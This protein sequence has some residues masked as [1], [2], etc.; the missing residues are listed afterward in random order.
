MTS[1]TAAAAVTGGFTATDPADERPLL[2]L[3]N[4]GMN[5]QYREWC[6]RGLH[7][8]YRLWLLDGREASWDRPYLVGQTR[9]DALD[10]DAAIAAAKELCA[11]LPVAGVLC[12][13]E[14]RIWAAAQI[15]V[16]VG[17]P[18]ATPDAILACRDKLRT[19]DLMMASGCK[20]AVRSVAVPDAAAARAAAAGIGY[21]VV[22]KPR[23]L[24]ASEGVTLARDAAEIDAR[25]AFVGGAH[26][27]E[28]P[29]FADNVLVEE[30]LDGPE[31]AL[32]AVVWR[33]EVRPAFI[34]RKEQ[35][36]VPTFEETGHFV[37][38]DDPL[39]HDGELLAALQAA[40][41]AVG[42][43]HGVTHTEVRL[44]SRGPRIVEINGRLGGDLIAYVGLLATGL[45]M[46]VAAAELACGQEPDLTLRRRR[47]AAVRYYYPPR[48]MVLEELALD[49]DELPPGIWEVT[50]L[51]V[52]G[53][54]LLLPPRSF[55]RGRLAAGFAVGADSRDCQQTLETL[56]R[57]LHVRGRPVDA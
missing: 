1:I 44:T 40:H 11:R 6:L 5:P 20:G 39:L 12:Y 27:A 30:Y 22:L 19:R 21:P 45:D 13:D 41:E 36:Q 4:S 42:F 46:A 18:T 32:D 28:V 15:A 26:F 52:A 47:T 50:L 37:S 17:L 51:G 57:L 31:F 25:F 49:P 43:D 29:D 53:R 7:R 34:A 56:G 23:A 10:T 8:Q 48:D 9:I 38:A 2:L 14:M 35:D 24:A 33:G 55:V 3:V 16:A 54:E